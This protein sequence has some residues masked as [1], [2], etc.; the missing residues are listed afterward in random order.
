MPARYW[1]DKERRMVMS[2]AYGGVTRKDLLDHQQNLISDPDFVRTFSQLADFTGMTKL[3]FTA[4]D[5]QACA[6]RTIFDPA[7]RRAIVVADIES[8]GLARMF[9]MLR[10]AQGE[11]GIRVVRTVEDGFAW[12]LNGKDSSIYAD[13]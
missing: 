6:A 2:T 13:S 11:S 4:L 1:I 10:D 7:A 8:F 12:I 5:V 9:E 3:D